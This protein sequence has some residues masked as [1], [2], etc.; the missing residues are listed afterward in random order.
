M[1]LILREAMHDQQRLMHKQTH[2]PSATKTATLV[3]EDLGEPAT[4]GPPGSGLV[5]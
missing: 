4:A 1:W 2:T 5:R 3:F